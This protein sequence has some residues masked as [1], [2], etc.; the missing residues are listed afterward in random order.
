MRPTLLILFGIAAFGGVAT[1]AQSQAAPGSDGAAVYRERCAMCH[2]GSVPRAASR[3]A[4]AQMS[5]DAIRLAL[6]SG[7]MQ[8]QGAALT[9]AQ[10][11]TVVRF[12]GSA[13]TPGS[14]D[15]ANE[16]CPAGGPPFSVS[17]AQPQWSGW[18]TGPTQRRFQPAAM[19]Q[20]RAAQIPALKLKW[21]FGFPGVSQAYAQP[22]IAGGRV[23][24]GSANRK[25]YSLSADTGCT[26]WTFDADA[27]VRAAVSVGAVAGGGWS[28]YFGDQRANA[29]SLDAATGQLRWKTHVDDFPTATITGA[30]TLAN[31]RLYVGTSS[32]EEGLGASP[33]YQCCRF[34][35]GVIALDASAGKVLWSSRTI[36]R[37]I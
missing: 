31:G 27:P 9:P 30:P 16:R 24:V 34:R 22:A 36:P 25:V 8:E 1:A 10:L 33:G 18:G 6:T 3:A 19:A 12:L 14:V 23:F 32:I 17:P 7:S 20:L 4:L 2:D 13:A 37:T 15:P 28:V 21:A 29:Y 11:D 5:P 35:G 26:Y